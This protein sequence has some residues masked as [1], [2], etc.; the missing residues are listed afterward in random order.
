ME[1]LLPHCHVKVAPARISVYTTALIVVIHLPSYEESV[2]MSRWIL[3]RFRQPVKR[4]EMLSRPQVHEFP[5][6]SI[7]RDEHSTI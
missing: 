7:C 2:N 3:I 6:Q 1:H 5:G 4:D